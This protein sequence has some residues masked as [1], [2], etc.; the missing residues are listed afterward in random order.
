MSTD[1]RVSAP[2]R[3]RSLSSSSRGLGLAR[4]V[5]HGIFILTD[6]KRRW[7]LVQVNVH[8]NNVPMPSEAVPG[9]GMAGDGI[10]SQYIPRVNL[11]ENPSTVFPRHP[12]AGQP[13]PLYPWSM[14]GLSSPAEYR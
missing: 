6:P 11:G 13:N 8:L 12:E 5:P 1:F 3:I 7:I 10:A 9:K 14:A 2:L 4:G